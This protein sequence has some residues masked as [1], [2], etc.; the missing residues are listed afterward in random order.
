MSGLP[1]AKYTD[2]YPLIE[3]NRQYFE[4]MLEKLPQLKNAEQQFSLACYAAAFATFHNTGYFTSD[5]LENFFTRYAQSLH[6]DLTGISPRPNSFLHVL[7][8]GYET[9]GHTRVVER[10][11]N[12]SPQTQVHSVVILNP[13]SWISLKTLQ[14]HV[15]EHN[16][17]YIKLKRHDTLQQRALQLRKLAM[18]YQYIILHTHMHDPMATLAFGTNEFTRPVF[19]YN[20]ASH[21]FWLGKNIA[22]SVLDLCAND[23]L[24][25]H[26]RGIQAPFFLGVP[27]MPFSFIQKDKTAL[28]KQLHIPANKKIIISAGSEPKYMSIGPDSFL[29]LIKPLL[30]KDTLVYLI[31]IPNKGKWKQIYHRSNKQIIPLGYINFNQGYLDYIACADLFVDS[32]PCEGGTTCIDAI[33]VQ[34]PVL[35]R[36]TVFPQFDYLTRTRAFCRSDEDFIKKARRILND[37]KYA[38]DF[39]D[40]LK[41]SLQ[42]FQ[43]PQAWKQRLD[44]FLQ[45][46]PKHHT[47]KISPTPPR[48][49]ITDL[50]VMDNAISNAYFFNRTTKN[51]PFPPLEQ[52]LKNGF[53][54]LRTEPF[55]WGTTLDVC[56]RNGRNFYVIKWKNHKLLTIPY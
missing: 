49:K 3:Q 6:T 56:Q 12:Y 37:T 5:V 38:A 14:R 35:S 33:T 19:F 46:A 55:V 29:R 25:I 1:P 13:R 23:P 54:W 22:D 31:G 10:W 21:L 26:T 34:V 24:T 39:Y 36:E 4:Q 15:H 40:E 43:S 42:T 7:T 44:T 32:Y 41:T 8:E 11:L 16:G 48:P 51:F 47:V 2:F 28:R 53:F 20:H 52:A 45:T 50:S 30:D 27:S 18:H 17:E 9:G